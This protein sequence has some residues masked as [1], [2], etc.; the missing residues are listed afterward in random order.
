MDIKNMDIKNMDIKNMDIKIE[1]L[2]NILETSPNPLRQSIKQ[3]KI[4]TPVY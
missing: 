3:S 2:D 4:L 1:T